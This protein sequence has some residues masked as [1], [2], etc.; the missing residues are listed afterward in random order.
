MFHAISSTLARLAARARDIGPAH[1][2]IQL[3]TV[4]GW[5]VTRVAPGTYRYRDPRFAQRAAT[6]APVMSRR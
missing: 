2:D 4:N 1:R 6:G 5:Q 3:A